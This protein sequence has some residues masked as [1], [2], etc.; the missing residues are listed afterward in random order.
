M[1]N[2]SISNIRLTPCS[3]KHVLADLRPYVC[4]FRDCDLADEQYI[5]KFEWLLHEDLNH[6]TEFGAGHFRAGKKPDQ[7]SELLLCPFCGERMDRGELARGKHLGRHMEEIAFAVVTKPYE[8]WDFYSTSSL[9]SE[10]AT[11]AHPALVRYRQNEKIQ[12]LHYGCT[13][14]FCNL[15]FDTASA[16]MNHELATHLPV[17]AWR[18][19]ERSTRASSGSAPECGQIFREE[20]LFRW[21]LINYHGI[22]KVGSCDAPYIAQQLRDRRV[23]RAGQQ[24]FWCGY[25]NETVLSPCTELSMDGW[26]GRF[27]HINDE[28]FNKGA[29]PFPWWP[30]TP[31]NPFGYLELLNEYPKGTTLPRTTIP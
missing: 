12:D 31:D 14:P 21:H 1:S 16:W 17:S 20:A 19:S 7:P 8:D 15:R 4:L 27:D 6:I 29:K 26:K 5:S 22:P 25:C 28:H 10:Y 2:S 30:M 9:R 18:C 13:F 24:R 23:G 3:R 11:Y